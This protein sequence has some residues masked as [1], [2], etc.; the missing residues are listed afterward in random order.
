[1]LIQDVESRLLHQIFTYLG[2][3]AESFTAE[4]FNSFANGG[5]LKAYVDIKYYPGQKGL[6]AL[7]TPC[8]CF[9]EISYPYVVVIVIN[10]CR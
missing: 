5:V 3:A 7:W 4:E 1:M 8:L 9:P 2:P 6:Q 10:T